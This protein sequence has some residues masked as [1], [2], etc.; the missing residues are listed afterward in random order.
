MTIRVAR[1]LV[2]ILSDS[3]HDPTPSRALSEP[4]AVGADSTGF[5]GDR[6]HRLWICPSPAVSSSSASAAAGSFRRVA[7]VTRDAAVP[8]PVGTQRPGFGWPRR[9]HRCAIGNIAPPGRG[10]V[11][12]QDVDD[13]AANSERSEGDVEVPI[14]P[15]PPPVGSAAELACGQRISSAAHP[16]SVC[17]RSQAR[18]RRQPRGPVDTIGRSRPLPL[19]SR[20]RFSSSNMT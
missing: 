17:G 4:V 1:R 19:C 10:E 7:S 5:A 8:P 9:G 6:D 20:S 3:D 13:V 2:E 18:N 12:R 15:S 11:A 14:R 16:H